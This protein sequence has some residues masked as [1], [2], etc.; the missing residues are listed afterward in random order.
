MGRSA[1]PPNPSP[2]ERRGERRILMTADTVGGVWS[3]AMD[4]IR[5]SKDT[6]FALATMGRLLSPDQAAEAAALRNLELFESAYRLEWMEQPWDDVREAGHWLLSLEEAFRPDVVHLNGLVQGAL[7][8]EAPRLSVV[9]SCVLSWWEAVKG[10]A[11]PDSWSHYRE[12]VRRSLRASDLVVAPSRAMLV[13]AERLYGPFREVAVV[14]NGGAGVMPAEKEPFVFAAGRM[15]DEAKNL[16][17]LSTVE[18]AW[19][20]EIAGEGSPLGRL[21]R[22]EVVDRMSRAGIYALPAKYEPFGLSVL[23]AALAGCALVIGDLPSLRENWEGCALFVA[24]DDR[25]ALEAA[26]ATLIGDPD[27]RR[28]LGLA[29]R[30]RGGELSLERFAQGYRELYDSLWHRRLADASQVRLEPAFPDKGGTS[31]PRVL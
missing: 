22:T 24:P 1:E 3:Y 17:A 4:L 7:P 30:A 8:F 10:E 2:P 27:L 28:R 14:P 11:A 25:G 19:P 18:C 6:E 13:E 23:E 20:I 16:A 29:A 21:P 31:M 9:H 5:E 12:E 26:L 15:W